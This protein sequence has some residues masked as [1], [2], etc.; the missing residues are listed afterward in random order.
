MLEQEAEMKPIIPYVL[1]CHEFE[2]N[3]R[4]CEGLYFNQESGEILGRPMMNVDNVKYTIKGKNN[5]GESETE[6]YLYICGALAPKDLK[7]PQTSYSYYLDAKVE[8]IIPTVTYPVLEFLL[9]P[10]LPK[11][12]TFNNE[13]GEISGVAEETMSKTVLTIRASNPFGSDT[14]Q[15]SF[16]V[17][18]PPYAIRLKYSQEEYRLPLYYGVKEIKPSYLGN[19]DQFIIEPDISNGLKFNP[20]TGI[21]SGRTSLSGEYHYT[22]TALCKKGRCDTKVSFFVDSIYIY[23]YILLFFI[24]L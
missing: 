12:L 20:N 2:I 16:E 23:Y 21:F 19:V 17:L 6:I 7:Y 22:V 3:P 24:Y 13:T 8:N 11:G 9:V 10:G 18:E 15:I 1:N 4:L 14:T 5:F